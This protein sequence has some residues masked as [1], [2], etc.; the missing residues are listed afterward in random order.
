VAGDGMLVV[1]DKADTDAVLRPKVQGSLVLGE[2]FGSDRSLDFYMAF[3]SRA[4]FSGPVGGGDYAAANIRETFGVPVSIVTIFEHTR[5][6]ELARPHRAAG[7][8]GAK[9]KH[10]RRRPRRTRP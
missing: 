9:A 2:V 1:R 10:E 4:A 7:A 6:D 8:I 5:L 3:S